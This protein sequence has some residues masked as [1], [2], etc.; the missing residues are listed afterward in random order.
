LSE[1]LH[2]IDYK[3]RDLAAK[4][5]GD[6]GGP[7]AAAPLCEALRDPDK[8]VRSAAAQALGKV[9]DPA[10]FAILRETL[11]DMDFGVRFFAA[12]ALGRV[13]DSD[14]VKPLCEALQDTDWGV[15]HSAANALGKIGDM[16]AVLNLCKVI[17]DTDSRVRKSAA[18]ALR[19]IGDEQKLPR[20]VLAT[21]NLDGRE[22]FLT[23]EALQKVRYR[24]ESSPPRHFIADIKDIRACLVCDPP[25]EQEYGPALRYSFGKIDMFC[26]SMLSD[27]ETSRGA[28]QVLNYLKGDTL[29]RPAEGNSETLMRPSGLGDA[30]PAK[31]LRVCQEPNGSTRKQKIWKWFW[32]RKE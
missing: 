23:L 27:P 29:V 16:A 28:N 6:I 21:S 25:T 8:H 12:D 31:L 15:R 14:A 11:R 10:T 22:R 24:G 1:A 9:G 30:S 19:R 18:G 26:Q 32:W 4:A 2:E 3:I 7:A 20:A 5:L 17:N 13:G